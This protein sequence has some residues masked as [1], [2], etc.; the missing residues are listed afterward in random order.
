M[1]LQIAAPRNRALVLRLAV[2]SVNLQQR[3]NAPADLAS[4]RRA[5]VAARTVLQERLHLRTV[6]RLAR[7][8]RALARVDE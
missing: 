6:L 7:R 3:P 8:P 4:P 5:Q 1:V 2:P